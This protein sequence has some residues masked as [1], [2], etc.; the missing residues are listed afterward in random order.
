[1]Y[2]IKHLGN[3]A[4]TKESL[5]SIVENIFLN[6]IHLEISKVNKKEVKIIC[7]KVEQKCYLKDNGLSLKC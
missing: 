7:R 5:K 6:L 3:N 2:S 1:M 4:I